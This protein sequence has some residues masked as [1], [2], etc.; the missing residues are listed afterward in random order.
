MLKALALITIFLS[1]QFTCSTAALLW[2]NR[3]DFA[4]FD[5]L[6]IVQPEHSL[7]LLLSTLASFIL[8][9]LLVWAMGLVRRRLVPQQSR[10]LPT[11]RVWRGTF[12]LLLAWL[13][14]TFIIAICTELLGLQDTAAPLFEQMLAHPFL[15]IVTLCLVGPMVEEWVFRE[16]VLRQLHLSRSN[17]FWAVVLS[18]L[19]FGLVH[20]N[21][22]QIFAATL[23]G[24]LLGWLYVRIG[25][26]R[27]P[28]LLHVFNNSLSLGLMYVTHHYGLPDTLQA[29][30]RLVLP[31]LPL[32]QEV[33]LLSLVLLLLAAS[34]LY[35][36]YRWSRVA[37]P[38]PERAYF[39][40]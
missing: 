20:L 9:F 38:M 4:H 1:V 16:G 26:V 2:L 31:R 34:A 5:P 24:L 30:V 35:A 8:T 23:L 15:A 36:L 19:A 32:W 10:A 13:P 22:V 17:K 6:L 39:E 25:D 33:G 21:P 3:H 14:L 12:W 27:Q 40:Q 7:T 29:T 28:M 11:R 18:A 37:E